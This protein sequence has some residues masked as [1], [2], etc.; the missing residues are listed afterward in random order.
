MELSTISN[1]DIE[2]ININ[3]LK[4]YCHNHTP[5]DVVMIALIIGMEKGVDHLIDCL[6]KNTNQRIYLGLT[7]NQE[8][9]WL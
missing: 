3:K 6:G 8:M 1:Y 2:R 4:G 9:K 5:I 7:L